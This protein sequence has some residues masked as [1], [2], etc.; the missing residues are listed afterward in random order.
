MHRFERLLLKDIIPMENEPLAVRASGM[1]ERQRSN[2]TCAPEVDNV[3]DWFIGFGTSILHGHKIRSTS[4]PITIEH[5]MDSARAEI[6]EAMQKA[7]NLVGAHVWSELSEVRRDV[8]FIMVY[9]LGF[10][11]TT[12]FKNTVLAIKRDDFD[13]VYTEMLDSKWAR[14]DSPRRALCLATRMR[15][16][17]WIDVQVYRRRRQ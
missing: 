10:A 6:Y 9:Q 13:T 3:G 2:E 17:R 7:P 16:D 12:K 14:N 8:L 1:S 4:Q 5:A 11:G 15:E